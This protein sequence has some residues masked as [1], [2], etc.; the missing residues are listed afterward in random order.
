MV[1]PILCSL[2]L[3]CFSIKL[4]SEVL[5]VVLVKVDFMMLVFRFKNNKGNFGWCWEPEL[6]EQEIGF[7]GLLALA[8]SSCHPAPP[9]LETWGAQAGMRNLSE[10]ETLTELKAQRMTGPPLSWT[11]NCCPD[12][13]PLAPRMGAFRIHSGWEEM[14]HKA[15]LIWDGT[16]TVFVLAR[17]VPDLMQLNLH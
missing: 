7:W 16:V 1:A 9:F 13:F 3:F 5:K 12:V 2:V 17:P 6:R 15:S 11:N 8:L 4:F 10:H 14:H